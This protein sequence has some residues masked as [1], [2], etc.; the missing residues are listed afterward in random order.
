[1][2]QLHRLAGTCIVL[3]FVLFGCGSPNSQGTLDSDAIV[4][5]LV[6]ADKDLPSTLAETYLFR[7]G[8]PDR[9][10]D[11]VHRF[12]VKVPLWSDGAI[13]TR[14]LFVP[15][16]KT[17][18]LNPATK[19]FII[20]AGTTLAKNFATASGK[21][22]ETRIITYKG[23]TE[24]AFATYV[25]QEDGSTIKN[26][27]PSTHT[28]E[29]TD[30]RIPSVSECE[31]CHNGGERIL[32]FA[33]HQQN[34]INTDGENELERLAEENLFDPPVRELLKVKPLDDPSD[35][36]LFLNERVRAYMDV[37]CSSC[38]N[39]QSGIKAHDMDFRSE[40]IDT[41]LV[42]AGKVIPG[43]VADSELWLRFTAAEER[44]PPVSLRQ[45]PLGT[46]LLF[47]L[48]ENWPR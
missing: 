36:S 44:M 22:V 29:G 48:I 34:F 2:G 4:D 35:T 1:M 23:G 13:K 41:G 16:G 5:A 31:M 19:N 3:P 40:A 7:N 21:N 15:P 11:G 14:F 10:V 17:I 24:W 32:G 30:F 25:W 8:Q 27:Y 18:G 42:R 12:D 46:D 45:D 39:P 6:S 9:P 33:P 38:H 37:N 43:V 20:P 47:Q 28:V 26:E